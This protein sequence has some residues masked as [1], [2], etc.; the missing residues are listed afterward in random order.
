MR[1]SAL[2]SSLVLVGVMSVGASIA[3]AAVSNSDAKVATPTIYPCP[4][5]MCY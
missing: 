2:L 4:P 5:T 3:P 1:L